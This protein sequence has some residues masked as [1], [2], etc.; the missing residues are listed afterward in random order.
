MNKINT[1]MLNVTA[2]LIGCFIEENGYNE[3]TIEVVENGLKL[4]NKKTKQ[5]AIWNIYDYDG[6][7]KVIKTK[8]EKFLKLQYN[9]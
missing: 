3:W 4:T 8:I 2:G 7:F 5:Y 6:D 9:R 1:F